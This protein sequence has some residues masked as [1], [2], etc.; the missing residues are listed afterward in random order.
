MALAGILLKTISVAKVFSFIPD[1]LSL[2]YDE[3]QAALP[4]TIAFVLMIGT[5]RA[6]PSKREGY[7]G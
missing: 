2:S 7:S 5:G 3:C 4:V 1:N 6:E